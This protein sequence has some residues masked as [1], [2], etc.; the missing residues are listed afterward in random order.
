MSSQSPEPPTALDYAVSRMRAGSSHKDTDIAVSDAAVDD[1]LLHDRMQAILYA[2]L[3]DAI[4]LTD[5][6][7][8]DAYKKREAHSALRTALADLQALRR[9]VLLTVNEDAHTA[10]AEKIHALDLDT[11]ERRN[12]IMRVDQQRVDLMLEYE[13]LRLEKLRKGEP[14]A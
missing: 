11:A 7:G 10:Y 9:R 1:G 3:S 13:K 14:H 5:A 6:A 8:D 2:Q 4:D 12:A